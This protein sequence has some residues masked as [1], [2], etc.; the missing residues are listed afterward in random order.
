MRLRSRFLVA[1]V[2]AV[3]SVSLVAVTPFA[4]PAAAAPA[5]ASVYVPVDP[6]RVMD[7]RSG[8]GVSPGLRS[9]G[10]TTVLQIGTPVPTNA[11]AV[12]LNVTLAGSIQQGWVQAYPTGVGTFGSSANLNVPGPGITRGNMVIVEVGDLQRVSFATTAGGHLIVDVFGYFEPAATSSSGRYVSLPTPRRTLDTRDPLL[13]PVGNPGDVL[14]CGDFDWWEEANYAFWFFRRYGDPNRLDNNG[15]GI[16]C[17]SLPGNPGRVVKPAD[18]T[19]LGDGDTAL[20]PITTSALPLFGDQ[21]DGGVTPDDIVAV[22]VNVT[23]TRALGP[24]YLQLG[25]AFAFRAGSYANLNYRPGESAPSLA[26]V[27]VDPADGA[28]EIYASTAVDVVVDVIGYFT[29]DTFPVS[30]SGLYVPF[31]P[32]RVFDSRAVGGP[33]PPRTQQSRNVTSP[34]GLTAGDV[35]AMFMNV[36]L[37]RSAGAGFLQVYPPGGGSPGSTSTVNVNAR[38]A[39]RANAAITGV[40]N[41]QVSVFHQAGGHYV[42]D[43]GGY[44]LR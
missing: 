28:I 36:T 21:P 8:A 41:G 16:P 25:P 10:S 5:A 32:D 14:D 38:G 1:A 37:A 17:E 4:P 33:L 19:S 44:F 2:L 22:V 40:V 11:T 3:T 12:V 15:D 24:G 6:V 27:P 29:G 39:T 43:A 23:A 35:A 13:T 18:A 20:L 9:P 42:L 26:I 7:T 31:A 34:A 30:S